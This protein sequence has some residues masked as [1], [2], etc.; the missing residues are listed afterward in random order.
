M[1]QCSGYQ[2][3]TN[4]CPPV[5]YILD[6][7]EYGDWDRLWVQFLGWSLTSCVILVNLLNLSVPQFPHL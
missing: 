7:K 1:L 5:R 6:L 4:P 2:T 3:D